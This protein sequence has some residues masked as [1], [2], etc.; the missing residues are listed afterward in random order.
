[1]PLNSV[2]LAFRRWIFVRL[3]FFDAIEN[4]VV[5]LGF[6]YQLFVATC[7]LTMY[8]AI[9]LNYLFSSNN[10]LLVPSD[11][12]SDHVVCEKRQFYF[13]LSMRIS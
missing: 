10:F 8:L 3:P 5:L 1:M 2:F 9:L 13:F 11:C 7:I 6:N 12:L 4:N